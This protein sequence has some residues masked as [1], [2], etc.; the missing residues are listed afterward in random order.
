MNNVRAKRSGSLKTNNLNQSDVSENSYK[1]TQ[2]VPVYERPRVKRQNSDGKPV[3]YYIHYPMSSA[4]NETRIDSLE[5]KIFNYESGLKTPDSNYLTQTIESVML[6]AYKLP[7]KI[8][9]SHR[10]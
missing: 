6:K 10:Y 5:E 4:A 1:Y 3:R 2:E 9:N 7:E 8:S